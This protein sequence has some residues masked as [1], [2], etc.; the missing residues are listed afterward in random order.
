MSVQTLYSKAFPNPSQPLRQ[1]RSLFAAGRLLNQKARFDLDANVSATSTLL[2]GRVSTGAILSRLSTLTCTALTTGVL[3][4]GLDRGGSYDANGLYVPSAGAQPAA[5]L[6][7]QSIA[8]A[9]A[10]ALLGAVSVA[11]LDA[12]VYT[13]MGLSSDPGDLAV[14]YATVTTAPTVSGTLAFDVLATNEA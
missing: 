6:S 7:A 14:I 9:G 3:N 5:L 11:N 10:F 1:P 4:V 12:R 8:T 2:I 13:L